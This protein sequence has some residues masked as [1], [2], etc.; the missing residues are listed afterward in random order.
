MQLLKGMHLYSSLCSCLNFDQDFTQ[1]VSIKDAQALPANSKVNV[2]SLVTKMSPVSEFKRK[3][4]LGPGR[5]R[6]LFLRD[7]TAESAELSIYAEHADS[8]GML[9]NEVGALMSHP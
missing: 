3:A 5:K 9:L 8:V 6:T 2:I 7:D 4:G 1:M